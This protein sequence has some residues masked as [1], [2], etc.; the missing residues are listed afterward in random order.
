MSDWVPANLARGKLKKAT[1][2]GPEV[3][4]AWA[5]NGLLRS[6]AAN[7]E[8]E[9]REAKKDVDLPTTFW[10]G[11]PVTEE[12]APLDTFRSTDW[13][14]DIFSTKVNELGATRYLEG[15]PPYLH[16]AQ[17][18]TFSAEDLTMCIAKSRNAQSQKSATLKARL[19]DAA[20]NAWFD[21]LGLE[22]ERKSQP[23]LLKLC[24]EHHPDHSISRQRIRDKTTGRNRGPKQNSR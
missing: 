5:S 1:G 3:L 2:K 10:L 24:V 22:A 4:I 9:W 6:H 8:R 21:N 17:F 11:T 15:Q 13:D 23:E 16:T 12:G 20:F 7:W 18:V 14:S 19:P